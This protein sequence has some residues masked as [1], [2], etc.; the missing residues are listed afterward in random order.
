MNILYSFEFE[1]TTNAYS[2]FSSTYTGESKVN[3]VAT[4][5]SEEVLTAEGLCVTV[6]NGNTVWPGYPLTIVLT[7]TETGIEV[8]LVSKNVSTEDKNIPPS[9]SH[10][11]DCASGSPQP[12]SNLE[13]LP[14]LSESHICLL[15]L[16]GIDITWLH[17][18]SSAGLWNCDRYG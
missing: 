2:T 13:L 5:P 8:S 7:S 3:V 9:A 6:E 18:G 17:D 1:Y 16:I 15:S 11:N 12:L 4:D 14:G 10:K